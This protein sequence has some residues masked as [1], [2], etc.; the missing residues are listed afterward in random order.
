VTRP[1]GAVPS[2][3]RTTE[4]SGPPATE[5]AVAAPES[6]P[7]R[8]R[9]DG[10]LVAV[11]LGGAVVR[12]WGLGAQSPWYDARARHRTVQLVRRPRL[13]AGLPRSPLP[14]P[15]TQQFSVTERIDLGS[16]AVT[17]YESPEPVPLGPESLLGPRV[18]GGLVLAT[19]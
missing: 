2:T 9:V 19:D 17:R 7:V 11:I 14:G 12:F 8:P 10:V 18:A 16:L 5:T 1:G 3:E 15:V 13:R 4:P 6:R